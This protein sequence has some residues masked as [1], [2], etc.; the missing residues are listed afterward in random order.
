MAASGTG[1]DS[2]VLSNPVWHALTT[3]HAALAQG[4]ALARRYPSAIALFG[5]VAT[6]DERAFA[7][8]E[9]LVPPGEVVGLVG[10]IPPTGDG[11]T[12]LRQPTLIQMVYE[13]PELEPEDADEAITSL[14][15]ADVPTMLQLVEITHPGPFQARTIELGRYLGI[16]QDGQLAAMAGERMHVPGYREISAVCTH[17]TFQRH[18]YAQRLIRHLIREIHSEGEVPFLHVVG[19]NSGAQNLYETMGFT[20]RGE[21]PLYILER[22]S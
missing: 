11:W 5:A 1:V 8:L 18:G 20:R 4:D 10:G 15:A 12:L 19:G 16:W 7:S 14:S 17:P 2:T 9:A 3:H 13:G 6:D 22:H 21:L